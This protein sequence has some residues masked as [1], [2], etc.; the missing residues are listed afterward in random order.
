[1]WHKPAV[2]HWIHCNLLELIP[3]Y[4]LWNTAYIYDQVFHCFR[5][6]VLESHNL[7]RVL[8][9]VGGVHKHCKW[10]AWWRDRWG[11]GSV[12]WAGYGGGGVVKRE[13]LHPFLNPPVSILGW[14]AECELCP[15][16]RSARLRH[17]PVWFSFHAWWLQLIYTA[18]YFTE[19]I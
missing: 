13:N 10:L 11:R 4:H 18:V 7:H 16:W 2:I 15:W 8:C 9:I 19:V 6:V 3:Q 14:E 1:M 17:G 5:G 12:A